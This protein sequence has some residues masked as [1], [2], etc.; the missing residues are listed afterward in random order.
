MC[1]TLQEDVALGIFSVFFPENYNLDY[2]MGAAGGVLKGGWEGGGD[3]HVL[4]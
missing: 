2:D 4:T 3:S 1:P